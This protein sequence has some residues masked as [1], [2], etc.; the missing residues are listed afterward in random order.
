MPPVTFLGSLCIHAVGIIL[1]SKIADVHGTGAHDVRTWKFVHFRK[2]F[3]FLLHNTRDITR[4]QGSTILRGA[5]S[6]RGVKKSQQCHKHFFQ[7]SRLHLLPK[8]LRFEHGGAKLVSF[9][10][11]HL[12]SL[13]ACTS[14]LSSQNGKICLQKYLPIGCKLSITNYLKQ[15][16]VNYRSHLTIENN[17]NVEKKVYYFE[18]KHN[19]P[20]PKKTR[21]VCIETNIPKN[22]KTIIMVALGPGRCL[23]HHK[24]IENDQTTFGNV[25]FAVSQWPNSHTFIFYQTWLYRGNAILEKLY[26]NLGWK[27]IY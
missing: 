25:K 14:R 9:P 19:F 17:L 20:F 10:R 7:N 8:D 11:R 18:S 23:L 16:A 21:G 5:E 26:S 27:K 13:R 12:T 4:G 15:N 6:L 24:G 3:R 2:I 1:C 22:S